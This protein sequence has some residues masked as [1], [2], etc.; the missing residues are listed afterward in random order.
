[1]EAAPY[2]EEEEGGSSE[3]EQEMAH[4]SKFSDRILST[5]TDTTRSSKTGK[6]PVKIDMSDKK[7]TIKPN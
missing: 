3:E 4:A 7:Y 1:M 6:E 2:G 5:S